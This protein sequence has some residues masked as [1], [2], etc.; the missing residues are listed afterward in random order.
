MIKFLSPEVAIIFLLLVSVTLSFAAYFLFRFLSLLP[1]KIRRAG[2]I[3]A[4]TSVTAILLLLLLDYISSTKQLCL[5]C[6]SLNAPSKEHSRLECTTCHQDSGVSGWLTFKAR[7]TLMR[8]RFRKYRQGESGICLPNKTCISCHSEIYEDI[9]GRKVYVRHRDFISLYRCIS[10]HEEQVHA[11]Y[12]SYPT[13]MVECLK[14]HQDIKNQENC[15]S[16]HK[17]P[18]SLLDFL[19][20]LQLRHGSNWMAV[21][22]FKETTYCKPCH[23][24]STFC[25]NC[26]NSFPHESSFSPKHG[27]EALKNIFECRNCHLIIKCNECHGTEMPHPDDWIKTHAAKAK[28]DWDFVCTRCH[29]EN[30]CL[31]CHEESFIERFIESAGKKK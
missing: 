31:N 18:Q 21:H 29:T 11:V 30:S 26:H 14:C 23:N 22:G 7:Q 20:V 8:L 5:S 9:E 3:I 25:K 24:E 17:A 16:C 15:L 10:C 6:H 2:S 4:I 28:I 12:D 1:E 19:T 13:A 27:R